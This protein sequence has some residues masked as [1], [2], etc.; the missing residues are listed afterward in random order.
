MANVVNARRTLALYPCVQVEH[1]AARSRA[2]IVPL[3]V[4]QAFNLAVPHSTPQ[5]RQRQQATRAGQLLSAPN[6]VERLA[7]AIASSKPPGYFHRGRKSPA[8]TKERLEVGRGAVSFRDS[9]SSAQATNQ[10]SPASQPPAMFA[11]HFVTIAP[12]AAVMVVSPKDPSSRSPSTTSSNPSQNVKKRRAKSER[13]CTNNDKKTQQP[14]I[15][16]PQGS[17]V[18]A[19]PRGSRSN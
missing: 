10:T 3:R 1:D 12:H 5:H 2:M 6:N 18:E 13:A 11:N 15:R 4:S 7:E 16:T 17:P 19:R 8:D 9:S 14:E